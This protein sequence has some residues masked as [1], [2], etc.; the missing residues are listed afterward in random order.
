[1]VTSTVDKWSFVFV[2]VHQKFITG[3]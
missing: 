2:S 1:M 3:A